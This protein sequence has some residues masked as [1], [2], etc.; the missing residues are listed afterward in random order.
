MTGIS[1]H[2]THLDAEQ[3][4]AF[5]EGVLP[6]HERLWVLSH[7]AECALCRDIIFLTLEPAQAE[8]PVPERA[9]W[10]K[11]WVGPRLLGGSVAFAI[12]M[13]VLGVF[14]WSRSETVRKS[15]PVVALNGEQAPTTPRSSEMPVRPLPPK[16][17][18]EA[19][20]VSLPPL[21]SVQR[22][23]AAAAPT[24]QVSTM[25]APRAERM[26]PEAAASG[27]AARMSPAK[28]AAG[29]VDEESSTSPPLAQAAPS[30]ATAP[31][32]AR[33]GKA[34]A[35]LA[36]AQLGNLPLNGRNLTTLHTTTNH[37]ATAGPL[38][39]Q[40][41]H[42]AGVEDG[43]ARLIGEV[44]DQS[45]AVVPQ[46]AVRL[47]PF[48]TNVGA[49]RNAVRTSAEAV[50]D[51]AGHFSLPTVPAGRYQA[52]I[53]APGFATVIQP[54][55]LQSRDVARSVTML[56]VGAASQTVEVSAANAQVATEE[57]KISRDLPVEASSDALPSRRLAV[58]TVSVGVRSVALDE[59]G[60]VF[61][62]R[63]ERKRWKR[64]K[65]PWA[66]TVAKL[67]SAAATA[68]GTDILAQ[69][70]KAESLGFKVTTSTGAVWGSAD[71]EHWV[72][73]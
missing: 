40:I 43:K 55:D 1:Q 58:T 28:M 48:P 45:G 41:E 44:L 13:L 36:A 8:M 21:A 4:A 11:V 34:A 72:Q 66:G 7:T 14:L 61:T 31:P 15:T 30:M 23:Q 25:L 39:L 42:G 29:S 6:E 47:T 73:Q 18:G 46:A 2:G 26:P 32:P 38:H 69:K 19:G 59:A 17:T 57:T 16:M 70:K 71:G 35:T 67:E 27:N 52:Q 53:T 68:G 64:V 33:A 10:W 63:S 5:A 62:R 20:A 65:A 9:P 49:E 3:V 51:S 37:T 12:L 50:T 22:Q 54:V 56:A 60:T 24:A